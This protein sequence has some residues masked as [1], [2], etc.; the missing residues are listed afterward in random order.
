MLLDEDSDEETESP[1]KSMSRKSFPAASAVEVLPN[2]NLNSSAS[3]TGPGTWWLL[4]KARALSKEIFIDDLPKSGWKMTLLG[5]NL[6]AGADAVLH[7]FI[8]FRVEEETRCVSICKLAIPVEQR[9]CG[10]GGKLFRWAEDFAKEQTNVRRI[11]LISLASAIPFYEHFGF[12]RVR[13]A[14]GA[15][16]KDDLFFPGQIHMEKSV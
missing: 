11:M 5:S 15:N 13:K 2:V 8:V 10:Y 12:R 14:V 4:Q 1:S 16:E 9:G 3:Q 7:G 6:Q